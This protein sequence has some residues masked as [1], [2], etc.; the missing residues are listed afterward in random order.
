MAIANAAG[1]TARA[2]ISAHQTTVSVTSPRTNAARKRH[3]GEDRNRSMAWEPS[4]KLRV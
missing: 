4:P 3:S 2:A 1:S